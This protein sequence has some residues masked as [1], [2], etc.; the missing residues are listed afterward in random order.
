MTLGIVIKEISVNGKKPE[1]IGGLIRTRK[2]T[3]ILAESFGG[4]SKT[5]IISTISPSSLSST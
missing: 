4:G 5:S 1:D 2:L 3:R